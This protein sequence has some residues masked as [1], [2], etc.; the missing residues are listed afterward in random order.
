MTPAEQIALAEAA[1][2]LP[3]EM[4]ADPEHGLLVSPSG[5][6]KLAAIAPDRYAAATFNAQLARRMRDWM[7]AMNS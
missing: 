5:A 2:V 1:G 6:R 4:R 3:H 7:R